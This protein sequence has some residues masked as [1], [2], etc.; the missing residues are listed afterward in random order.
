MKIKDMLK[1][2]V[3]SFNEYIKKSVGLSNTE[4]NLSECKNLPL[5]MR[6]KPILIYAEVCTYCNLKCRMC[7]RNVHGMS[8]SDQGFMK[9]ELFEN[10]AELFTQGGTLGLFGRGETLLHPRFPY[11]LK[12][13]K[14]KGMTVCFNSN[15]KSLTKNI[16]KAMVEYR[17]NAITLSC[18]AGKAET[19]EMIHVGGKWDH[20]WENITY[21]IEAKERYGTGKNG[22]P[23]VYLE[24]VSQKDNIKELPMLIERA[25]KKGLTGVLVIDM[26]A[27]SDE[28]EKQR[29]NTPEMLPVA[30]KY[31]R[32]ALQVVDRLKHL[33]PDFDFRLP[34]DYDPV[35]KKFSMGKESKKTSDELLKKL[36][37][38]EEKNMCLEPWQTFY[39][40]HNGKVA[41]CVITNRNLGDLNKGGAIEIW[42]GPNFQKFRE[43]M[44]SQNKPFECLRCHLFPGP[45]RYDKALDNAGEYEP[46]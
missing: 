3:T 18:S 35:T 29:M 33:N 23:S 7:G 20:L 26:V 30:E 2:K 31:Y 4:M 36:D 22:M 5:V 44:R 6:S 1:N 27:H 46:L 24:F 32:E 21:L 41:P 9:Q 39:V 42:N 45:Q 13:A 17:Q 10:L 37:C 12:L 15:G 14:E 11:F 43:R 38:G 16:A 8:K 19:Y 25:I 40:R 34:G 28:L